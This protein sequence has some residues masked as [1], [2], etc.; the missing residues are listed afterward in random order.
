MRHKPLLG[1]LALALT[2][3]LAACGGSAAVKPHAVAPTS[4]QLPA[5]AGPPSVAKFC[6]LLANQIGHLGTVPRNNPAQFEGVLVDFADAVPAVVA[7]APPAIA[8]AAQYF[9]GA[10]GRYYQALADYSLHVKDVP[11][12]QGAPLN[13][14]QGQ[15]TT[16]QFE[17]WVE[18]N[19]HFDPLAPNSITPA[20]MAAPST[21]PAT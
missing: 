8:P 1:G 3:W 14:A 13:S 6:T 5:L 15:A 10:S 4:W 7:A 12:S 2:G 9:L 11:P 21:T 16:H 20:M 17:V 19:C 18:Q